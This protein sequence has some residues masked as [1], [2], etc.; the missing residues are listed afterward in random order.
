MEHK[1]VHRPGPDAWAY[2]TERGAGR[3]FKL[4]AFEWTGK[5]RPHTV[6]PR[7]AVPA[8]IPVPDYAV[9]GIPTSEV[10]SRQQRS[11]PIRTPKE[12]EGMRRVCRL[13][14]EILDKAHAAV[15]PGVT[16]DEIDRIVH[17]A[18]VEAG[19]YPSPLN[20]FHFPKSVCTSINE[21]ICNGIPDSRELQ[22]GDV[23]NV[24]VTAYL[25][26]WH[27]D[28]NETYAVGAPSAADKK[29][30][31]VTAEVGWQWTW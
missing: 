16:T 1:K 25:D 19:A 28:L 10:E 18:T 4:P 7:R 14:R 30:I 6:G 22:E 3:S 21:V 20:Y 9:T 12:I 8:H 29:L 27:G 26:G 24:D 5:L 11:V 13:A 15:A 23:V 17:D 31:R 2:V